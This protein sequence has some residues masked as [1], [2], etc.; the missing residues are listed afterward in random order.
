MCILVPNRREI[1][2]LSIAALRENSFSGHAVT[3]RRTFWD[4]WDAYDIDSKFVAELGLNYSFWK[5]D[6]N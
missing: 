1:F 3:L 4:R 2:L 6:V 5:R